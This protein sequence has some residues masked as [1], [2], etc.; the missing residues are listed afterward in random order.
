MSLSPGT[1]S[2]ERRTPLVGRAVE[3]REL[4]TALS[5]TRERHERRVVTLI[6]APGVGKTRLVRDFLA[7]PQKDGVLPRVFRGSAA[8]GGPAFGVLARAL[9]S[10]FGVVEGMGED[11]AKALVREQVAAVLDDRKVNDICVFIG[12]LLEL[13]FKDSPLLDAFAGDAVQTRLLRRAVLR[14]FLEMD[15]R[16]GV[17]AGEG[18][19]VL[20]F[21]DLHHADPDSRE[22]L[23]FLLGAVD[24]PVLF[25]CVARPELFV[26]RDDLRMAGGPKHVLIELGPLSDGHS[27]AMMEALLAPCGGADGVDDLVD[28][29]STLAGGNPALLEQMVRIFKDIGVLEAPDAF[30]EEERWL[31]HPEKLSDVRVPLTVEDAISARIASLSPQE[32]SLL[33][34]AAVMG[35]VF[36]LGGL[37]AIKRVDAP[38]PE[39]WEAVEAD[40]L[41]QIQVALAALRDRDYV[42]KL[43]DS[44]F[45]GDQEYVFKHNLEREALLRLVPHA[46]AKRAHR[47]IA[48]WLSFKE[49][50]RSHEEYMAMLARHREL[51]GLTAQAALTYAQAADI[52]RQ[53]YANAKSAELYKKG[54]ELLSPDV[55]IDIDA[56]VT[57]LH[58][59]GDVL[60]VLGRNEEAMVAFRGML[61]RA[62]RLGLEGKGGAAH[63]R[64]GRLF[65]D[66]G[67]LDEAGRHLAAALALF[68]AAEDERGVASTVD[69]MGKLAWL[70]GDY[71]AALEATQRALAAR[72]RI[73]DRRSIALSLNNLGLVY[74]DSGKFA[75][76][77]DSFEQALR[78][79]RE[80][81]DLV[82]VTIS[83]NN[84]GTVAQDQR[85]DARA[86]ALFAE[87]YEVAKETGDRN[88][89]ALVLTNLGE[90]ETRLGAPEKAIPYLKEAEEIAEELGD[91]LGLAEAV[92]GL[93]KAYL[94]QREYTRAREA[95]AKAVDLFREI[96]SRV[97]LGVALRSLGEVMA[98]ASAGGDDVV[99]ARGHL[100]QSIWIFEEIG[101]DV[102]V[103][104][105][106]RVYADLLRVSPEYAVD[107]AAQEEEREVRARAD[108]LF[109]KLYAASGLKP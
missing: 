93:G 21:D 2:L 3:L 29:A 65:R 59:Y 70:R 107:P 26:R 20:V 64:I 19:L 7:R 30:S 56:H 32:R 75:L 97:Q 35:G 38:S 47:A 109:A 98:A 50:V 49:S 40:D 41:L 5:Q 57:A 55:E 86:R 58:H 102:E 87:A 63:G 46:S 71:A 103:A 10:R 60:Q 106:C 84:L 108:A 45:P 88:R 44:T 8:E 16:R 18:P 76:A 92:R 39:L 104:R 51:G 53:R 77:L 73:G 89:I 24:A 68:E 42:L 28:A 13:R 23:S 34:Y 105:S 22:L 80:I 79:R 85:D 54:L 96:Q 69:D 15:A 12:E 17:K 62:Y 31:V 37:V 48:D 78:I 101:N 27:T 95:I 4:D 90:T 91:K 83:L 36:W 25:V 33:E 61:E 94:A 43:P 66:T 81:G 9:R 14:H 6:G 52:A 74:Q 99:A 1:I 67:R 82:G 72:R 100:L 11:E